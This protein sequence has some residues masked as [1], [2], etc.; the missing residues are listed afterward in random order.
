MLKLSVH[1]SYPGVR[2][3][4]LSPTADVWADKRHDYNDER[5]FAETL[6]KIMSSRYDRFA[7]LCAKGLATTDGVDGYRLS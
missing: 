3:V 1:T 6:D 5:H 7:A 4:S 2:H